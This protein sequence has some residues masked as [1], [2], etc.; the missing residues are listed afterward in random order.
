M[1]QVI[2]PATGELV[3]EYPDATDAE[4]SDAVD[5]SH[6]A[7]LSWRETP[8]AERARLV[9]RA[10]EIFAERTDELA[11]IIT[12]EMGKRIDESKGELQTVVSIFTYYAEN[13][14][15]LAGDETLAIQGGNAVIQKRPIGS[16]IGIMPWNYP[17]YQVARFAAPN[18]VLGNT[19]ILKHARNCPESAAAIESVLHD[20]GIPADAYINVYASASQIASMLA[21]PRVQGVSL[22][23]SERAGSAVA[24]E[25]GRNLKKV[26]LELGGS[27]PLVLLDS[28][29]LDKTVEVAVAARMG[30]NGQACN[31]PKRMIVMDD[32]YDEF[33]K[34]LTGQMSAFEPGDPADPS[35]TLAP[36]SSQAAADELVEQI[37]DAVAKGATLHTGGTHIDGPGAYV[38]PA[39]LTGVTKDMHAYYGEL[40]GPAV[41]VYRAASEEEAIELANDTV[42]GLGSGVF[43]ADPER[44]R[45]VGERIDAGM[46]YINAAGGSQADL[47]FGGIK[48]SGV[49]RELGA[50]GMEEFMNKKIVR[51]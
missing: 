49:G 30:N 44:A 29:D 36:L 21:D 32:I 27:D 9:K 37:A 5:R 2:N 38:A 26:V 34:K 40:F 31:A 43:S 16:L 3:A 19:I 24:M 20:A 1:Y 15:T 23:G 22:T 14:P 7:Y 50:L 6:R 18:L 51:L 48:R 45:R 4:I 11:A 8:I 25:A 33:V 42:Y 17:Y 46:V 12:R 35:T 28:S 10:A 41:V 39:V 47:P 13:G